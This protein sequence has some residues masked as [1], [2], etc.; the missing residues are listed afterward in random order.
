M[1]TS[2]T[3]FS[4]VPMGGR[5]TRAARTPIGASILFIVY[6]PRG[7]VIHVSGIIGWSDLS[8]NQWAI[9]SDFERLNHSVI[10]IIPPYHVELG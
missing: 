5:V 1:Q 2:A 3:K 9:L 8:T 4:I 6:R 10:I 7:V